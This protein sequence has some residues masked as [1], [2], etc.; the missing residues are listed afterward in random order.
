MARS[1]ERTAVLVI[2]AWLEPTNET[3][4]LRARVT[5]TL[6]VSVPGRRTTTSVASEEEI[7]NAVRAWL[8]AFTSYQ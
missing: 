4:A 1:P 3:A 2:R 6:D 7:V 5:S 8:R